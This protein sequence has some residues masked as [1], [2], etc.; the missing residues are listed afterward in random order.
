[1]EMGILVGLMKMPRC[2]KLTSTRIVAMVLG[3]GGILLF[4]FNP[5]TF[6]DRT[7]VPRH[8]IQGALSRMHLSHIFSRSHSNFSGRHQI[9]TNKVRSKEEEEDDDPVADELFKPLDE[10]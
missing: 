2:A 9:R 3:F 6:W 5:E 4:L 8:V 10:T 7:P 1:M